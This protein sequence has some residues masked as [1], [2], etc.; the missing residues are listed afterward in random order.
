VNV[1]NQQNIFQSNAN[2]DK[3]TISD[4]TQNCEVIWIWT[5]SITQ[6]TLFLSENKP[7]MFHSEICEFFNSIGPQFSE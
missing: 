1:T 6:L 7:E 4:I 5:N 3:I 2:I